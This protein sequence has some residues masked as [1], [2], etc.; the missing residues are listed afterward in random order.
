MHPMLHG[1]VLPRCSE[2]SSV[3]GI[4]ILCLQSL[5]RFG[6]HPVSHSTTYLTLY[7]WA[8]GRLLY[9]D[10]IKSYGR[11]LSASIREKIRDSITCVVPTIRLLRSFVPSPLLLMGLVG[12]AQ[13]GLSNAVTNIVAVLQHSGAKLISRIE[14]VRAWSRHVNTLIRPS[15]SLNDLLRLR[16]RWL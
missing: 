6:L 16:F 15:V 12:F 8:I 4:S 13:V 10:G 9:R 11:G 2:L 7:W 3:A 1:V 5:H 14:A